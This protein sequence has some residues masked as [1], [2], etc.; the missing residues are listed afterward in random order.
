MSGHEAHGTP[1][2]KR[3]DSGRLPPVA[4]WTGGSFGDSYEALGILETNGYTDRLVLFS[5][6]MHA[7]VTMQTIRPEHAS[8]PDVVLRFHEVMAPWVGM[9]PHVNVVRAFYDE[10]IGGHPFIATDWI[11]SDERGLWS[12]ERVVQRRPPDLKTILQWTADLCDGLEEAAISGVE[13]HLGL[14]PA[15]VFV[16]FDGRLVV[17]GFGMIQAL[18]ESP[19]LPTSYVHVENGRVGMASNVSNMGI[20]LGLPTHMPAEQFVDARACGHT[21]T[22]YSIGVTLYQLANRGKL[23]FVPPTLGDHRRFLSQMY[24]AHL[25]VTPEPLETPLM[26]ILARLMAKNPSDRYP[27]YGDLRDDVGALAERLGVSLL[28][29]ATEDTFAGKSWVN[30][31]M[32]L[33]AFGFAQ[34]ALFAY[35]RAEEKVPDCPQ[36][37]RQRAACHNDLEQ[38]DA[39]LGAASRAIE[40]DPTETFA[41]YDRGM[42][43][44]FR[45]NIAESLNNFDNALKIDPNE[46]LFWCA[47]GLTLHALERFDEAGPAYQRA[48]ELGSEDPVVQQMLGNAYGVLG[49]HKEALECL[50]KST[51]L[52]PRRPSVWLD[53]GRIL[54]AIERWGEAAETLLAGID[55]DPTLAPLWF[56]LGIAREGAGELEDAAES[57]KEYLRLAPSDEIRRTR[58][59][60]ARLKTLEKA[61]I[62]GAHRSNMGM[63]SR[64]GSLSG[65][66]SAA[67]R[68]HEQGLNAHGEGRFQDAVDA[69]GRALGFDPLNVSIWMDAAETL[70]VTGQI[71]EALQCVNSAIEMNPSEAL[72]WSRLGRM[73][74]HLERPEQARRCHD[75]ALQ[76]DPELAAAWNNKGLSLIVD[77][78]PGYMLPDA[79]VNEAIT[80]FDAALQLDVNSA[81][82]WLGKGLS[83]RALGRQRDATRSLQRA[84]SLDAG[85]QDAWR[86]LAE[87]F[88]ELGEYNAAYEA[89]GR[90]LQLNR[91]DPGS[92]SVRAAAERVM[93][94][95]SEALHAAEQALQLQP[96][97]IHAVAERARALLALHRVQEA[98][99]AFEQALQWAPNDPLLLFEKGEAEISHGVWRAAERTLRQFL[100]LAPPELQAQRENAERY[101]M[102]LTRMS[103]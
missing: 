34:S 82:A 39:A 84:V 54:A 96:Q 45:G 9:A 50:E 27:S 44:R 16:S 81:L 62:T 40:L 92:W 31:G 49:F 30:R 102:R 14:N 33:H 59:A 93:G 75:R 65:D 43:N 72:Q 48:S 97:H 56:E 21:S 7:I 99:V 20:G 18:S 52:H 90:A 41:W 37:W 101:L 58:E 57:F 79:T 78:L 73:L 13:P 88:N 46:P 23:P 83:L 6:T 61:G 74:D 51:S 98:L 12:L 60:K 3:I 5:K 55:L 85:F 19:H 10:E 91:E 70:L 100:Q 24:Q 26:P 64:H 28:A 47:K 8:H 67:G 63:V 35:N 69:F 76:I 15:T 94:K 4:A 53:R 103:G 32:G 1:A 25:T 86:A 11:A 77:G 29:P 66:P 89:A 2:R 95:P 42:V 87:V 17:D 22:M 71:D 36:M 38:H 80:C 68:F